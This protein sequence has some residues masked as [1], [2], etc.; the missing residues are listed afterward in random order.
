MAKKPAAVVVRFM[1]DTYAL[2]KSAAKAEKQ[3]TGLQKAGK[4]MSKA[5][6]AGVGLAAAGFV[7][8]AKK[9]DESQSIIG[10]ATGRTGDDLKKLTDEFKNVFAQQDKTPE[11]IAQVIG[12]LDTL[13]DG[14][15]KQI[16]RLTLRFRRPV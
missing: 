13:V 6:I 1:G 2:Q 5:L 14:T 4:V 9:F 8:A 7:S 16:G 3:L 15:E 11:E 12:T 10:K